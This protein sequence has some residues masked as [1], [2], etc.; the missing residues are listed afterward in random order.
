[1]LLIVNSVFIQNLFPENLEAEKKGR[2]TTAG[3]KIKVGHQSWLITK[4]SGSV[5]FFIFIL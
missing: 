4:N 1:M 3:A 2:P 5:I